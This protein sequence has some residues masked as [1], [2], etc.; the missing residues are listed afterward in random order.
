MEQ[1]PILI[2]DDDANM[3]MALTQALGYSGY[4]VETAASGVDALKRFERDKYGIVIT[5]MKMPKMSGMEVLQKIKRVSPQIPII[6]ITAYGTID[7]AVEAMKKGAADYILKP[8]SAETLDKVVKQN[9]LNHNGKAREQQAVSI[10][11]P[12]EAKEIIT[13]NAALLT[14]LDLARNVA[15]TKATVL[16]QGESGTGK[17]LL[18]RFVHQNSENKDRPF[19]AVNCAALPEGLAESE[20]FGHEKGSF[21]GAVNRKTGKFELAH[22]GTLVLDEI[23]EMPLPLQAKMLRVL[24]EREIDIVGG[25]KPIPIDVR[26]IA[27]SNIDLKNAV[28]QG[29]FREDLFYRLNVIPLTVPPLRERMSD[30]PLL[31]EYFLRHYSVRYNRNMREIAEETIALLLKYQWRGNV[32]ELK[33][34]IERAVLLGKGQ[35]LLPKHLFLEE[36]EENG[37]KP[38]PI[39]V[40]VSLRDME[41]ELIIKTLKEVHD[42]RTHAAKI[43]GISIRTLRN[44]LREYRNE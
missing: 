8:F 10:E 43:L 15:P 2:V 16:I 38:L 31:A 41:K 24:Q 7:N 21:T 39:T 19:V 5:D 17:E 20:L 6:M 27:I 23:S 1:K 28:R 40:G 9:W 25:T 33:N 44:K 32:R 34:S 12:A 30:I 37:G 42:N 22:H 36:S 18:A 3:R 14:V 4:A 11:S 35:V 26:T 13:H 29:K